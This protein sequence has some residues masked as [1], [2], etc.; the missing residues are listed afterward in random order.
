MPAADTVAGR[1]GRA[2]SMHSNA[3]RTDTRVVHGMLAAC[4][5]HGIVSR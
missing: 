3:A 1:D 2:S 4:P 5:R